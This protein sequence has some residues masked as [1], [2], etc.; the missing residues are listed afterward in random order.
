MPKIREL[1]DPSS[2][3][4]ASSEAGKRPTQREL[5]NP[6]GSPSNWLMRYAEYTHGT[7]SPESYHLWTGLSILGSAIRRNAWLNQ[8]KYILYPNLYVILV[9]PAGKMAKSTTIRLGRALLFGVEGIKFGPDAVTVEELRRV[10]ANAHDGKQ[11][12]LTLHSTELSDL[13]DPSGIKM[14]SFLTTI[15]DGDPKGWTGGTKT[16]GYDDIKSPILNLLGGTTPAWLSDGLP[17]NAIGHGFTSRVIFVYEDIVDE[18]IPFPEEP[19][20]ELVKGLIN[21]LEHISK[22]QGE[23]VWDPGE[24]EQPVGKKK[25]GSVDQY[26][27][28]EPEV[29]L[30]RG[31]RWRISGRHVYSYYYRRIYNTAVPDFRIEGYHWRKRNHLLK[32]AMLISLA[33]SDELMLTG[34]D[35]TAAW[36]ILEGTERKMV[37]TFSAVG[38]Y[39]HAS[40][41]ERILADIQDS[42]GLTREQIY[43]KNYAAADEGELARILIMLTRMNKIKRVQDIKAKTIRYVPYDVEE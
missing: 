37:R 5:K 15:Y 36:N 41:L 17:V 30:E 26:G 3:V 20:R 2:S 28:W 11:S 10:M 33:G 7:E 18:P 14:V 29:G 27:G 12:A 4:N 42:G 6:D 16:Q 43:E 8:G 13:I 19:N 32:V 22:I 23:F 38:K 31:E 24:G 21:D 40:D 1:R 39:E 25:D 9:G 35:I 34:R